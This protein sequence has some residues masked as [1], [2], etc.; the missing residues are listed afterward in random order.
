MIDFDGFWFNRNM[1][2]GSHKAASFETAFI[3][4]RR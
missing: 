3:F 1:P 2:V 4:T